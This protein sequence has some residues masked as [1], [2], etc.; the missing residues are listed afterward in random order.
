MADDALRQACL[1]L[2]Y[3]DEDD[4]PMVVQTVVPLPDAQRAIFDAAFSEVAAARHVV[5]V[6]AA[7]DATVRQFLVTFSEGGSSPELI[8]T[9]CG[10]TMMDITP[11]ECVEYCFA[12]APDRWALAKVSIAAVD[13]YKSRKFADWKKM[14]LTG[15][16]EAQLRRMLKIGI[17]S[18]L[19]DAT[20]FPTPEDLKPLYEVVDDRNGKIIKLPHPVQAL[21]IWKA[22]SGSY[23]SI[24]P[25]LKDAPGDADRQAWWDGLLAELKDIR[26]AEYI[27]GLCSVS[28]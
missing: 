5:A 27:D 6:V 26:G 14:L 8:M 23:Q 9:E 25:I 10:I 20:L 15:D 19:F 28:S 17:V 18:R 3:P 21:R 12:E 7:K 11:F 4:E 13:E 2:T 16:C 24:E 22:E 1:G